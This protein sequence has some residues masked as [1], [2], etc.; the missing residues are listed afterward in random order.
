MEKNVFY[1]EKEKMLRSMFEAS[2]K[3]E[4]QS[5]YTID[6]IVGNYYLLDDLRPKIIV[7]DIKT[8]NT[9]F[10]SLLM[11]RDRAVLIATGDEKDQISVSHIIKN[12]ILK[13]IPVRNLVKTIFAFAPTI[14]Q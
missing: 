3:H 6:S 13:P 4:N 11:Y 9:E 10:D 8:V 7:F 2:F 5:I 12:F 14:E 1:I